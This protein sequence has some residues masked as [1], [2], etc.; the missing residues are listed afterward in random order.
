MDDISVGVGAFPAGECICAKARVHHCDGCIHIRVEQIRVIR[1]YLIGQQHA[2]VNNRPAGQAGHIELIGVWLAAI[3]DGLFSHFANN[4]KLTLK[5]QS[6]GIR[7]GSAQVYRFADKYLPHKW[8]TQFGPIAQS[9]VTGGHSPPAQQ[10]LSFLGHNLLKALFKLRTQGSIAWQ[11]QHAHAV[12]SWRGQSKA[13][14]SGNFA[15][16]GVR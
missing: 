8:L 14:L 12:F 3:T 6:V 9:A 15:K 2:F 16:K 5:G 10:S 7:G 1:I 13:Q 11:K 4:V